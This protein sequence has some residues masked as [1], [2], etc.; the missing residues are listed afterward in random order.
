MTAGTF[1]T[2]PVAAARWYVS[3]QY[4]PIP[5]TGRTKTIQP[6]ETGVI[7]AIRVRDGQHVSA[8][9]ALIELD[10]TIN[11]AELRHVQADLAAAELDIARLTAALSDDGD[12]VANFRPPADANVRSLP[13]LVRAD[14]CRH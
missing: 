3:Q 6:F 5:V 12:P 11:A 2:D 14:S 9:E 1:P 7:R 8:G 13:C 10:P 4:Q